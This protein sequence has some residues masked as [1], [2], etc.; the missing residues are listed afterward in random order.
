VRPG[1]FVEVRSVYRGRVRWS[2]PHRVV[3]DDGDRFGLH[4]APGAEGV[5]MG[6]DTEGRYLERWAR[7]DDPRP[8]VCGDA[9]SLW[10][11][12]DE[13]W[14]FVCWYVQLWAPV[15]EQDGFVETM[16]HALDVLVEPDGT[17]RWKDEDDFAEAQ[18]LG[19]FTAE[20]AAAIRA[21]GERVVAARPW[22]TGWEDWRP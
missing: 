2:F 15:V 7:G 20:E 8:H 16:D 14:S 19:I 5:W 1:E 11:L 18:A 4:L 12:W 21:E 22:P 9:H 10:L 3:F 6:R 13:G 17:W